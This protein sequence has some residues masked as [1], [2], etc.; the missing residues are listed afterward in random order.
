MFNEIIKQIQS[1]FPIIAIREDNNKLYVEYDGKPSEFQLDQITNLL[2][3]WPI[4]KM[5]YLKTKE[6]ENNWKN[7]IK[8]GLTTS[9]GWNLGIDVQDVALLNGAFT[10]AKEI[11]NL[12]LNNNVSIIDTNGI[13]HELN[14]NE[15]TQL[16]LDYGQQRSQLSNIYA[17]K[18]SQVKNASSIEELES[19]DLSI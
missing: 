18:L 9:Y 10:L 3:T 12:G 16:M 17:T 1:I 5:Q 7:K 15:L 2:L 13:S 11:S 8:E 14:I 19:L 4:K 6:I